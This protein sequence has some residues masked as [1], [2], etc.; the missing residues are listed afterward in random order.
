MA[1]VLAAGGRV[2]VSAGRL[3]GNAS[4]RSQTGPGSR[5]CTPAACGRDH[6][7]VG[8]PRDGP[9][10]RIDQFECLV[11]PYLVLAAQ[12]LREDLACPGSRGADRAVPDRADK[13]LLTRPGLRTPLPPAARVGVLVGGR[14]GR[15]LPYRQAHRRGVAR[16]DIPT[17]RFGRRFDRRPP[18]I[19]ARAAV[20]RGGRRG[21]EFTYDNHL[22][23]RDVLVENI[24]QYH[25][26][27]S[28]DQYHE[29]FSPRA[30]WRCATGLARAAGLAASSALPCCG[31]SASPTV[32]RHIDWVPKAGVEVCS[33]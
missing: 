13:Q 14:T 1:F 16:A 12:G 17:G 4:R 7:V 31:R 2:R 8:C 29:W 6:A 26:R 30:L 18:H 10:H 19:Q 33:G 28:A 27:P 23:G 3:T 5:T 24:C 20:Q 9:A 32:S 25:P 11:G 21:R 22:A 15:L